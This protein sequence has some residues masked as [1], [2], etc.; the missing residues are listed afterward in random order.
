MCDGDL[1]NRPRLILLQLGLHRDPFVEGHR[2][3]CSLPSVQS[4]ASSLNFS[5]VRAGSA[6]SLM[7]KRMCSPPAVVRL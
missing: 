6:T 7:E 5:G 1:G 4:A 3:C 2:A